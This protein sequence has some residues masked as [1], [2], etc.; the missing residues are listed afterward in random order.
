MTATRR[1]PTNAVA[2][3]ESAN[4]PKNSFSRPF[5]ASCAI[6]ERLAAWAGPTKIPSPV[7][8]IQNQNR[9]VTR[10]AVAALMIRPINANRIVRRDPIQ[11]ST[12]A[13]PSAP[14]PAAT[15]SKIPNLVTSAR[16]HFEGAGGVNSADR[17]N[18]DQRVRIEHICQEKPCDV[19]F[20]REPGKRC[21]Q[22]RESLSDRRPATQTGTRPVRRPNK[23]RP[24]E[25]DEPRPDKGTNNTNMLCAAPVQ[26]QPRGRV[27]N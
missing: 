5:G 24:R 16:T 18:R 23:A 4:N 27:L 2:F 7:P 26:G 11:S 3:P 13:K 9:S 12:Q 21:F 19:W 8:A 22:C 17:K 1:G 15:L 20:R 10:T 14:R 6:N 25:D